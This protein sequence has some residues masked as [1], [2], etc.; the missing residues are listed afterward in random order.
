MPTDATLH[1]RSCP[2]AAVHRRLEDL[3]QQWHQAE[4]EYFEPERFRVAVQSAIQTLRT[5]TFILQNHK[6]IIRDFD[7]WYSSW[8][9]QL[10]SD[11]LMRWMV[12]AR[13]KIEKEGDLEANS[14]VRA[15]IIASYLEEGPSIEVPAHL[16][17][18]P[19]KLIK[20]IPHNSLGRR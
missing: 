19:A 14:F 8:Q 13:N 18:A 20:S 3:H 1:S 11:P 9:T 5:V 2:L 15:R 17:D 7:R 16:F 10:K 6:R 12:D 4:T